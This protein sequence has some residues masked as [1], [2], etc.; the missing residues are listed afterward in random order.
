MPRPPRLIGDDEELT[1]YGVTTDPFRNQPRWRQEEAVSL[2]VGAW[3]SLEAGYRVRGQA[4][5]DGTDAA[6]YT[7]VGALRAKGFIVTNTPT[8]RNPDHVSVS[9]DGEWDQKC[10]TILM[11]IT[12]LPVQAPSPGGQALR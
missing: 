11:G 12:G 10:A 5:E 7:T 4:L 3:D 2:L 6:R 8:K 1:Q 9:W